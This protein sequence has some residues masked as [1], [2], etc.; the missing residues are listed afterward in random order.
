MCATTGGAREVKKLLIEGRKLGRGS[1]LRENKRRGNPIEKEIPSPM[2]E[3]GV[4][5][6]AIIC[7]RRVWDVFVLPCAVRTFLLQLPPS[8]LKNAP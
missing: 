3:V 6:A 1:I 7:R 8:Q 4:E 2:V 5:L